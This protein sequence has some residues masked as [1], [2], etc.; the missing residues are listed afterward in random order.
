MEY[1]FKDLLPLDEVLEREGYYKD[2]THLDPETFYS[3]T[4]ISEM[5][6][7][8]GYGADVRLL[9][10]KLAEHFGL[11][12]V[13]V[14]DI[15]N[16]LIERQNQVEQFNTQTIQEMTNKDVISAPE[17]IE[18]RK[19]EDKLSTRLDKEYNEV[20][21]QLAQ[22]IGDGKKAEL[23]DLSPTVLSAIEGGEGT[24]FNL[25]SI[26]QDSSVT[27]KKTNFFNYSDNL[28]D[29]K[30]A[31]PHPTISGSFLNL[32]FIELEKNVPI[33]IT[34]VSSYNRFQVFYADK[35][36]VYSNPSG[37]TYTPTNDLAKYARVITPTTDDIMVN[38][39]SPLDFQPYG[40]RIKADVLPYEITTSI[41][42]LEE[43]QAK[44]GT[45][46]GEI[47]YE[48]GG[49]TDMGVRSAQGAYRNKTDLMLQAGDTITVKNGFRMF[50]V[51]FNAEDIREHFAWY[52]S[53]A[54]FKAEKSLRVIFMVRTSSN[55]LP[56][57]VEEFLIL[58]TGENL[59]KVN[60]VSKYL[61]GDVIKFVTLDGS[62][63]NSGDNQSN[64]Y[65]T[66]QKA[67]DS[68]ATIVYI[69]RGVYSKQSAVSG[70]RDKLTLLPLDD[71]TYSSNNPNVSQKIIFDGADYL[72]EWVP[73]DSIFSMPLS[74]APNFQNVF[75]DGTLPP[76]TST[77]RPAPNAVLWE[78]DDNFDIDYMMT[79]TLSL[80]ECQS[81]PKTFYWDGTHVY[82]NP[83]NINNKFIL[84][85]INDG[86]NL[87]GVKSLNISEIISQ[88]YIN[89]PFALTRIKKLHAW[90]CGAH[91]SAKTDGFNLDYSYGVMHRPK[92]NKNRNDGF[93]NH[94]QGDIT[95]Y[96]IEARNN[97]DDGASPHEGC[98]II[99][100]G[101]II[102][103]SGKGGLIPA[104]GGY[105][106]AY[107][108]IFKRNK[109]GFHNAEM[110]LGTS[111]SS[112]NLYID[113]VTAI[114]N[115]LA[116]D[117]VSLNDVFVG[118]TTDVVGNIA[119]Y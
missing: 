80:S 68:G 1:P 23:E 22:K 24:S 106:R 44:S 55:A 117:F 48:M 29:P 28:Y 102:E 76:M 14:T 52:E 103:G 91:R 57:K 11:S 112:G 95:I 96:D 93:N 45:I 12:V 74:S 89:Q 104:A 69:Q 81:T 73:H 46:Y 54:V 64:A 113:N 105:A 82:I 43:K 31:I 71:A 36:T 13:E 10:S 21:A 19:G 35:E 108:V 18:A 34:P 99:V 61:T 100:H 33:N 94:S 59:L 27:P 78:V 119:R 88:N 32:D 111:L 97:F 26:P 90:D 16:D 115:D 79:P 38:L 114:R 77:N 118:N 84:P 50:I 47:D 116:D 51:A 2:W 9:I 110:P 63:L 25:L 42:R 7:T 5:I 107:G 62:D 83:I 70:V 37:S 39:G 109:I 92:A 17:L 58:K 15:A 40:D 53:N 75:I 60:E 66:L 30:S 41:N 8:K 56:D 72:S 4:Q 101:G 98:S 67:L 85:R 49:I 87:S 6:K 3:I 20:T 86:I 65:A